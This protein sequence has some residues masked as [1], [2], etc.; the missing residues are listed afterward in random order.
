[1]STLRTCF[2]D[3]CGWGF[4]HIINPHNAGLLRREGPGSL[5]QCYTKSYHPFVK[6][7]LFFS[8]FFFLFP[9]L[10][11]QVLY[12]SFLKSIL[13][14]NHFLN[15]VVSG[16]IKCSP[17]CDIILDYIVFLIGFILY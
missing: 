11:M 8:F 4:L 10:V 1:M 16:N 3:D 13:Y 7:S 15:K 5:R 2:C 14:I 17:Y 12:V 6:V 9:D